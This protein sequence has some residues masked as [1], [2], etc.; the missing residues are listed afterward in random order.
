VQRAVF[1]MDVRYSI[2]K[3]SDGKE[4]IKVQSWPTF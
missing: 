3:A 1:N 2:L 4:M